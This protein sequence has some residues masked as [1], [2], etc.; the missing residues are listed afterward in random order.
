MRNKII[1]TTVLAL[2]VAFYGYAKNWRNY[3]TLPRL[4]NG[5]HTISNAI[6]GGQL[7]SLDI[8]L[9]DDL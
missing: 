3:I 2:F 1:F 8:S 4:L 6:P 5:L 7:D 9:V